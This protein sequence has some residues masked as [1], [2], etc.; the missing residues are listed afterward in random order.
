MGPSL[1]AYRAHLAK[2]AGVSAADCGCVMRGTAKAEAVSCARTALEGRRPFF[3]AFQ[4]MGIDS[5]IVHGLTVNADGRATFFSWDSDKYGGRYGF[6]TESWI[7][8]EPCVGPSVA[9]DERP[10]RCS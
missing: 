8:E 9:D 1:E 6:R 4:V 7:F 5:Q 3:V 10:I 2:S